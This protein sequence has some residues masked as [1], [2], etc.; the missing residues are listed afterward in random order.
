MAE[1][2]PALW[3]DLRDAGV[4]CER[5]A[6]AVGMQASGRGAWGPCPACNA[7]HRGRED[8]R[9]PIGIRRDGKGWRCHRCDAHGDASALVLA[10]A[11]GSTSA[12]SDGWS[13]A[14]DLAERV[15]L[16][17]APGEPVGRAVRSSGP[18]PAPARPALPA[19]PGKADERPGVPVP[20]LAAWWS[21]LPR[22]SEPLA[23][24]AVDWLRSRALDPEAVA[25]L[26]LARGWPA[27]C[28]WAPEW[29]TVRG[30]TWTEAGVVAVLPA[31]GPTGEIAGLR[32]RR[33][34]SEAPKEVAPRGSV[35]RGTVLADP[36]ARWLLRV[37]P[38]AKAGDVVPGTP[39][40]WSG[41]L[42][43]VEGVPDFLTHATAPSR[44]GKDRTAAVVGVWSGGWTPELGARLPAEVVVVV[45]V[46]G[47]ATGEK[48]A[49]D[50]RRTLPAGCRVEVVR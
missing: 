43:V 34:G 17:A 1:L 44:P 37:G 9:G 28:E 32:A 20:E 23:L 24:P 35:V 25:V 12:T 49:N 5:A 11:T 19:A 40:R 29:A 38:T 50:V 8:R 14:R 2:R 10:H 47:D 3:T 41:A 4:T 15:G 31:F 30:R 13:R 18:G 33:T 48:Y 27:G 21:G 45:A 16:V 39:W 22:L 42:V 26:D 36:V 6:Q 46:H 7:T